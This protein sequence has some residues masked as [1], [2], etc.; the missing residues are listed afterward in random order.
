MNIVEIT[1]RTQ[2]EE[3]TKAVGF[4]V[5]ANERQIYLSM[6]VVAPKENGQAM[7]PSYLHA[8][9]ML[10]DGENVVAARKLG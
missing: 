7:T 1:Y 5:D 8:T 2:E 4:L 9:T 3:I 6:A 10:I